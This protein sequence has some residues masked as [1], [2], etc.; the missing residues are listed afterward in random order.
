MPVS[1]PLPKREQHSD[2]MITCS[3]VMGRNMWIFEKSLIF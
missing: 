3:E 2:N 1:V